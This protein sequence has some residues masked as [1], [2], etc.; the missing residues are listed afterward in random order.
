[1]LI[2][3]ITVSYNAQKTIR[4][5][6]ESVI[7]Q[8]YKEIEYIIIDGASTDQTLDI[9]SEYKDH[10]SKIISEPDKGIYNAINKGIMHANGKYIGI[11][12]ADDVLES[13]D[14]IGKI[15]AFLEINDS[16]LIF[17]NLNI[18][19]RYNTGKIIRKYRIKNLSV[20][21]LRIG[22]MPP[23]PTVFIK[24]SIYNSLG[25]KPYKEN[26]K[27]AADFELVARLLTQYGINFNYLQ[28]LSVRMKNGGLSS[29]SLKHKIILN[30]EIIK[31][32]LENGIYTNWFILFLKLPIRLF[33][34][35]RW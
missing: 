8:T 23:H 27:I 11:L 9:I 1:M 14:V 19:N 12:N 16:D 4:E 30:R 10:I 7:Y 6:I 24:R 28:L 33:E 32:C 13:S 35:L 20:N 18:V 34:Y 22:I 17:S 15:V 25:E 31:S 26:Y 21:L 29:Q 5:T 2:T 3:I